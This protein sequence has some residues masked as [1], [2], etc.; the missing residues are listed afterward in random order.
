MIFVWSSDLETGDKVIDAQHKELVNMYNKL[1]LYCTTNLGKALDMS[2][3]VTKSL[4]FLCS[5]TVKH[6]TGEETLQQKYGY[7]DLTRHKQLHEEFKLKAVKLSETFEKV[8]MSEQFISILHAQ[9]GLWLVTHIQE[10]D[11]KMV[12]YIKDAQSAAAARN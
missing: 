3:E 5:Y 1:L 6:F 7:P 8:G 10:E 2:A 11:T 9:I 12:K 4:D